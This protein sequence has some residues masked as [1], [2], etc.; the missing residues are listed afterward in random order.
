VTLATRAIGRRAPLGV[1]P[2]ELIHVTFR[3]V[4]REKL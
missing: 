4:V 2:R 1:H 3:L